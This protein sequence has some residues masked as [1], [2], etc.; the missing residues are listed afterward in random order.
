MFNLTQYGEKPKASLTATVLFS[1]H[2]K[3]LL[4]MSKENTNSIN[5]TLQELE[6]ITQKI[7]S[8]LSGQPVNKKRTK[9]V[10]STLL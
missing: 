6:T 8:A 5:M 9:R 4:I 3:F 2:G 1:S 7:L 10:N